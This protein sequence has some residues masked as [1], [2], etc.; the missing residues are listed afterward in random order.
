VIGLDPC[1]LRFLRNLH[2]QR[3]RKGGAHPGQQI[4]LNG[5]QREWNRTAFGRLFRKYACAG[6]VARGITPY[7]LRHLFTVLGIENGVG[8]RQLAD[9]LGHTTTKFVA[10][11]GR[12]TRFRSAHLCG[13]VSS[14]LRRP[15][16]LRLA[17]TVLAAKS[18]PGN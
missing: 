11:Y 15:Q 1:T 7:G 6:G 5:C 16:N 10:Y 14:V 8:E 13:V 12:T 2:R 9:Q 18:R 3:S 4:F 17:H